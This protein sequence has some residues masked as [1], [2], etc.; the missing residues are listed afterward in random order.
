MP[1]TCF[2]SLKEMSNRIDSA[3][4][5]CHQVVFFTESEVDVFDMQIH[6]FI[7]SLGLGYWLYNTNN[8]NYLFIKTNKDI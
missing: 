3:R 5:L 4:K 6:E 8:K 2:L 1:D 7:I